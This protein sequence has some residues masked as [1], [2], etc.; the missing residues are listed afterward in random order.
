MAKVIEL[1][2]K[3]FGR[4]TVIEEAGKDRIFVLWRCACDCGQETTVRG[5]NLRSGN[6]TSCGCV[7]RERLRSAN[8]ISD[9]PIGMAKT[10]EYKSWVSMRGRCLYPHYPN[11]PSYGG[12][13]IKL[14]ERWLSFQ[15]FLADMGPRPNGCS[16]DRID[17]NGDYDPT[18]CRWATA[19][20]QANN[21]R[22]SKKEVSP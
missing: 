6:T 1:T 17:V 19:K 13:G 4:L 14:C 20:E 22:N 2:G 10:R 7:R 11:Y 15:N 21:R 8:T 18:N 3:R 9:T 12:R 16:I 5:Y